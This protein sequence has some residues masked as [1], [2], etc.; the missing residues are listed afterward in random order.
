MTVTVA[1]LAASLRRTVNDPEVIAAHDAAMSWARVQLDRTDDDPLDDLAAFNWGAIE[2]YARDWLK[3]PR[4][5]F[6]YFAEGGD[7]EAA[8]VAVGDIARR[9]RAM[10]CYGVQHSFGFA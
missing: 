3:L 1:S 7:G 2:G 9:H 8:M 4:A 6:G 5:Q 10:L